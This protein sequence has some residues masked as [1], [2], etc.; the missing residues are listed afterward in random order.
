MTVRFFV[1]LL[2]FPCL[3]SCA[4]DQYPFEDELYNCLLKEATN[5]NVDL[6]QELEVLEAM[7]VKYGILHSKS[8]QAK[9]DFYQ[10]V[11]ESG[12]LPVLPAKEYF[13]ENLYQFKK[14]SAFY[15]CLRRKDD[16]HYMKT[17]MYQFEQKSNEMVASAG[18][19]SPQIAAEAMIATFSSE[20][21]EH[22]FY[23]AMVLININ[24]VLDKETAYIRQIPK[25]RSDSSTHFT[26]RSFT[27][28]IDENN[29][30]FLNDTIH[31][32]AS[33]A[34][35]I[36]AYLQ[37]STTDNDRH[38]RLQ[39]TPKT[40]Y[41]AFAEMH[42]LIEQSYILALS[43]ISQEKGRNSYVE[44]SEKEQNKL[45]SQHPLRLIEVAP[46]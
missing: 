39:V 22:P 28:F 2:L 27:I 36:T 5:A 41:K 24:M 21:L 44:L 12:E 25:K 35:R 38:I 3:A 31:S 37:H 19:V 40:S 9:L 23:R 32:K 8:G 1:L 33:L 13:N 6:E 26:D 20:D 30:I 43:Q 17:K 45:R 46:Q 11:F 34:E 10:T 15:S 4:S 14:S 18:K 7:Y 29:A 16:Q 42:A